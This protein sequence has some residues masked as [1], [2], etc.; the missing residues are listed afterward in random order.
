MSPGGAPQLLFARLAMVIFDG[1]INFI[2]HYRNEGLPVLIA[3]KEFPA[4][5]SLATLTPEMAANILP[6][7]RQG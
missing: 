6:A 7:A 5:S 4:P 1:L 3:E 2:C